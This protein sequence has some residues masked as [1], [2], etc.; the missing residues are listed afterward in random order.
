MS[1]NHNKKIK[2]DDCKNNYSSRN[3]ILFMGKYRC[4]MCRN[5][6]P[7]TAM[8]SRLHIPK[9]IEELLDKT[10]EIK[11]N[12]KKTNISG[13]CYFNAMLIGKKFK[14]QIIDDSPNL[15]EESSE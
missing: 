7:N 11:P 10:Y 13:I 12:S 6:M 3:V 14:I 15:K 9:K 4:K 5:K 2:C 8:N 1:N